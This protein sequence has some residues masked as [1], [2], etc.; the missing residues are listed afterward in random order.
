M[1]GSGNS[2]ITIAQLLAETSHALSDSKDTLYMQYSAMSCSYCESSKKEHG[3][4]RAI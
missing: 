4:H 1:L 3:K 2:E